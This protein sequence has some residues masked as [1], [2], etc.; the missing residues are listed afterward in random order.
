MR[1]RGSSPPIREEEMALLGG[2][3]SP[4]P[5]IR[6]PCHDFAAPVPAPWCGRSHGLAT[7]ALAAPGCRRGCDGFL[8]TPK[9]AVFAPA[10]LG[11]VLSEMVFEVLPRM[12]LSARLHLS[13]HPLSSAFLFFLFPFFSMP[14]SL[15]FFPFQDTVG[16][17]GL[18]APPASRNAVRKP[19]KVAPVMLAGNDISTFR[20][21][22]TEG[23]TA[24]W[25]AVRQLLPAGPALSRRRP[26][27]VAAW[28]AEL[29]RAQLTHRVP[30]AA[31]LC[32]ASGLLGTPGIM[33][34]AS[35]S[36][37]YCGVLE[38][39]SGP[40]HDSPRS[41]PW[42]TCVCNHVSVYAQA[43]CGGLGAFWESL[44][45]YPTMPQQKRQHRS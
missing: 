18:L 29:G 15:P 44:G 35:V 34:L 26:G 12:G 4:R 8:R 5:G 33:R 19:K 32:P 21:A 45:S 43:S 20:E 30:P 28:H 14:S 42:S 11:C 31:S 39:G 1:R 9:Q 2:A 13:R 6:G 16:S 37:K 27:C 36:Q 7:S 3:V 10:G 38:N 24:P 25:K 22:L 41:L 40:L 23:A 17:F